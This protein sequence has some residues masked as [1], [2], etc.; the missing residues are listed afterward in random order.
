MAQF[1]DTFPNFIRNYILYLPRQQAKLKDNTGTYW[2][3]IPTR[4]TSKYQE[5]WV[6]RTFFFSRLKTPA[7]QYKIEYREDRRHSPAKKMLKIQLGGGTKDQWVEHSTPQLHF[8]QW[9]SI[10]PPGR[11]A[12]GAD[13]VTLPRY[14]TRNSQGHCSKP[15]DSGNYPE[16]F[17]L[18]NNVPTMHYD[19]PSIN[20]VLPYLISWN[21]AASAPKPPNVS[22]ENTLVYEG[23]EFKFRK[24]KKKPSGAFIIEFYVGDNPQTAPKATEDEWPGYY[25]GGTS[26]PKTGGAVVKVNGKRYRLWFQQGKKGVRKTQWYFKPAHKL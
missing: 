23:Q 25:G 18:F 22:K 16:A 14:I 2:N 3:Y 6:F 12:I 8:V 19:S 7:L 15:L 5:Q 26:F 24:G 1:E 9:Q 21:E 13:K 17:S 20:K 4:H 11:Q 10:Q